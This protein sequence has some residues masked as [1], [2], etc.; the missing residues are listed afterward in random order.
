M[1][2]VVV[3]R[4]IAGRTLTLETGKIAKLCN[5][6]VMATY[7]GTTVLATITRGKPRFENPDFLGLTVDY[8]EKLTAAGKFPGGFKKRE[9]PPSEKEILTMRM[10]D[11]PCRP[12][13]PDGYYDELN[14]QV[15]VMS[16]DGENDSD[17]LA[18]TAASAA[19][20][21]SDVPFEGPIATVRV[22]RVHTD[23]GP[24]YVCN[25]TNSQMEFSDLD[26]VLSGHKDGLNM[27][28]VGAAELGEK[29]VLDA[30]AFGQ[31]NINQTLEL[32]NELVG[33]AGVP[34]VVGDLYLPPADITELVKNAAEAKMIE[35]RKIKGKQDRN[36][37]VDKLRDEVMAAHFAVKTT[38]TYED[39]AASA[40]ASSSART[41][42]SVWKRRSRAA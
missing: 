7:G 33:K 10:I 18:G 15:F 28:E 29:V 22:A 42:S 21:I 27:I 31:D 17:V 9:G 3:S 34:K 20:A 23:S 4:Q 40:S 6:A 14:L 30:I 32:I 2:H 37:A 36:A 1:G 41:P 24:T 19:M 12:L 16:H 11:R 13:F 39:Y 5:G 38:G 25:P 26:L 8:R 35:A